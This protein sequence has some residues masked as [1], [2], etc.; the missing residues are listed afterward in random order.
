M[1]T[2]KIRNL[3]LGTGI[4][5]ICIPNIGRTRDEILSL[6]RQYQNMHMDLMEWRADW[7]EGVEEI[8]QVTEVLAG[9]R[10]ILGDTPLL[11]TFRTAREGGVRKMDTHTYTELNKAADR[12]SVV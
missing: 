1:N 10:G 9:I 11:F 4:P 6:T 5:A 7:F 3:T 12:K 8:D 2:V